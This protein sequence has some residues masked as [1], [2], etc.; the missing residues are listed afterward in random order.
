MT[1]QT[2]TWNLTEAQWNAI[3]DRAALTTDALEDGAYVRSETDETTEQS[4][5]H[6][7]A[8][9][10]NKPRDWRFPFA[11]E[12]PRSGVR[13]A[14]IGRVWHE[15]ATG[16][17]HFEV[18]VYAAAQA[19]RA[20]YESG[21]GDLDYVAYEQEVE[22]AVRGTAADEAW[23]LHEFGRLANITVA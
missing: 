6:F 11:E 22:R 3:C 18:I 4:E 7:F 9:S 21:A 5:V 16:F 13:G 15:A 1:E 23:L 2:H 19:A 20:D 14:F 17:V 8:T 10:L 12:I